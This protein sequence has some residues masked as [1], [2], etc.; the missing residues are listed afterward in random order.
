MSV[1]IPVI[2]IS[3]LFSADVKE[4]QMVAQQMKQACEDKGFFY[5]SNHGIATELQQAVFKQSKQFFD[6][7]IVAGNKNNQAFLS[8]STNFCCSVNSIH[9]IHKY[10]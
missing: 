7:F 9:S 3:G 8:H 5:I 1:S 6:S 4:R 2:D 10:V